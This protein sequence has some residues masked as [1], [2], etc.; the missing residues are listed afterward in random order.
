MTNLNFSLWR[1]YR[2]IRGDLP[3][4][5]THRNRILREIRDNVK[6]YLEENP[7]T[8]F[9]GIQAHF[10][11]PKTIAAAYVD[12]MDT[13]E[14]L[15]ALR[16]RRKMVSAV[17]SGVLVMVLLWAGVVSLAYAQHVF[18]TDGY[19]V[20]TIINNGVQNADGN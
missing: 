11:M 5:R 2:E 6:G 16:I 13:E 20:V 7:E 4:S 14:L 8:D 17:A 19:L 1:Y 15:H 12:E 10:G 9:A 3:C 18:A